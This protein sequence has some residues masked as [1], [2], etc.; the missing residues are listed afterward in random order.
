MNTQSSFRLGRL[1]IATVL[2]TLAIAPQAFAI[3]YTWGSATTG[4]SW[5]VTT[6]WTP[7]G[8][9]TSGDTALLDNATV[10]RTVFYDT[11][12]S[13]SLTGLSFTQTTSGVLNELRVRRNLAVTNA[14][15]LGASSGTTQ[16][17]LAGT[18]AANITGTFSGGITVNSGG[19]LSLA[20]FNPAGRSD[21]FNANLT[22]NVTV[23]G[24]RLDFSW[25]REG[26][27]T[28]SANSLQVLTGNLTMSS[29]TIAFDNPLG[30]SP[31]RRL[32][33]T[34]DVSITGGRFTTNATSGV[35]NIRYDGTSILFAPTSY[36]DARFQIS[37]Q[38]NGAQ[39]YS[40]STALQVLIARGTGI[41][42]VSNSGTIGALQM[43]DADGTGRSA[44]T[45]KLASNLT[46][47]TGGLVRAGFGDVGTT[48][49]Y[50]VDADIYTLD[51]TAA[52]GAWTPTTAASTVGQW[53]LT[54]TAGRIIANGFVLNT[55][56]VGTTVGPGLILESRAGN[57]G[58]NNLS[59]GTSGT[60]TIDPT[61]V[62]RY[63]GSA[64]VATPSTLTSSRAIGI[65]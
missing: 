4:G 50:G 41:K 28:S 29:G 33:I 22:G 13:G 2:C 39:T 49:D 23:S 32:Q 5:S 3:D 58:A 64:A 63:A 14:L 53:A 19:V 30:S 26:T 25:V 51:L 54:G 65:L 57:S 59:L 44:T 11:A 42:T 55:A 6:N 10:N 37:L 9:P 12:A 7:N 43:M 62:F 8:A 56:S 38:A 15:V 36:D 24:G 1:T 21:V 46:V 27:A 48:L 47:G 20:N 31:D 60:G 17:T 18:S 34:G 35:S 45:L 61:S 16:L 52:S 40:G